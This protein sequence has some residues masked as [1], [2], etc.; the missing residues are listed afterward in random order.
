MQITLKYN[1][2]FHRHMILRDVIVFI[3]ESRYQTGTNSTKQIISVLLHD[4]HGNSYLPFLP[5][6][7]AVPCKVTGNI[8]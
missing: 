6:S 5:F 3:Y 1:A 7:S 8:Q 2:A 4:I